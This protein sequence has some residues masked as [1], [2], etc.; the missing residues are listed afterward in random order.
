MSG[1]PAVLDDPNPAGVDLGGVEREVKLAVKFSAIGE[2][3]GHHTLDDSV[4]GERSDG[5][6]VRQSVA[7]DQ[8]ERVV[9]KLGFADQ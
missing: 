7:D 5:F 2:P 8:H 9:G 4:A 3:P 1:L 6:R